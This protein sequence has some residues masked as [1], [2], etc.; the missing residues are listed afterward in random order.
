MVSEERAVLVQ[1]EDEGEHGKGGEDEEKE[2]PEQ[3]GR[4][5]GGRVEARH[6]LD[7]LRACR[8]LTGVGLFLFFMLSCAIMRSVMICTSRER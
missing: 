8:P 4:P 7:L 1:G 6:D 5:K 2:V 3:V